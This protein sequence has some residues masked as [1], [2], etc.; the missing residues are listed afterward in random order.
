MPDNAIYYE[1]AY[2]ATAIIYLGYGLSLW[3]R[4]RALDARERS[5]GTRD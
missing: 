4:K 1:L 5:A 2:A 3:R